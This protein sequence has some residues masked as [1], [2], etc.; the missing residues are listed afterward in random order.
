V[1]QPPNQ[2]IDRDEVRR[3]TKSR[4]RELCAD[5]TKVTTAGSPTLSLRAEIRLSIVSDPV[6]DRLVEDLLSQAVA[7][8]ALQM[9]AQRP[10]DGSLF[11][12]SPPTATAAKSILESGYLD[13]AH[14]AQA[15]QAYH[16]WSWVLKRDE[17]ETCLADPAVLQFILARLSTPSAG[18][19]PSAA[20][21][22]T[23][24]A[25]A[26]IASPQPV[27]ATPPSSR[28]G[29][30]GILDQYNKSIAGDQGFAQ[31]SLEQR[32]FRVL[33]ELELKPYDSGC[34]LPIFA[35]LIVRDEL[36]K[37]GQISST[38]ILTAQHKKVMRQIDPRGTQRGYSY[39]RFRVALKRV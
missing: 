10:L 30:R 4:I 28:L 34:S 16:G 29:P 18:Q 35:M 25:A 39:D 21:A 9:W 32:Y 20:P 22:A 11:A 33:Q 36:I 2:L 31:L 27:V 23:A 37:A 24:A 26:S 3:A 15:A 5:I 38:D 7:G 17:F 6:F 14:L 13:R 8:G 19:T 1:T 12:V